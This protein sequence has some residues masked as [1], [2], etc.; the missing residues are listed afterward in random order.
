MA[1]YHFNLRDGRA[2]VSDLEGT[3][4]PTI[5]AARA[6]ATEVARQLMK[7]KE[8]TNRFWRLDVIDGDGAPVFELPFAKVDPTLDHLTPDLRELVE[9]L[10]EAQ[11]DLSETIFS[12]ESLVLGIRAANA[13]RNGRPYIAARFGRRVDTPSKALGR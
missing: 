1:V 13:K 7:S 12:A 4:L 6:H 10:A 9:Q 11:R 2:G 5:D 8:L 3:D